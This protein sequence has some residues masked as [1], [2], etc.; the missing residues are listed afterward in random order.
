[1]SILL[2]QKEFDCLQRI[3]NH[4][5]TDTKPYFTTNSQNLAVVSLK[6][7]GLVN[8]RVNGIIV[9]VVAL[10]LGKQVIANEVEHEII[11]EKAVALEQEPETETGKV[12]SN[13]VIEDNVPIPD[14]VYTRK[15]RPLIYPLNK[16]EVGQSFFIP[17]NSSTDDMALYRRRITVR[18]SQIK[19]KIGLDYKFKTAADFENN[20]VRVWRIA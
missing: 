16:L 15:P 13:F 12:E 9:E 5:P 2:T 17:A 8:T 20:G 6:E 7:K 14:T 11:S 10:D 3:V 19:N 4:V 18:I 1:M